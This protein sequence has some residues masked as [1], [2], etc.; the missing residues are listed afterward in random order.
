MKFIMKFFKKKPQKQDVYAYM[1]SL[2]VSPKHMLM[3]EDAVKKIKEY[4]QKM[5]I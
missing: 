1:G 3:Y 2:G 4:E 5:G